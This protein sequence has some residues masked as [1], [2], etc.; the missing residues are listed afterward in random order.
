MCSSDPPEE[1]IKKAISCGIC[2]LNINTELQIAWTNAV[3][4]FLAKDVQVYDPRKVIK[5]GENVMKEAIKKKL[6]LL[7]SIG[8]A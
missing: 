1:Q 4:I 5:S 2:K 7:G 8:K 3:R 6:E